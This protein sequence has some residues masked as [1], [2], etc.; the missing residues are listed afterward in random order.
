MSR[1]MGGGSQSRSR[2]GYAVH[3]TLLNTGGVACHPELKA[4][5][6]RKIR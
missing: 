5:Y 4:C 6:R 3:G 2:E 1:K